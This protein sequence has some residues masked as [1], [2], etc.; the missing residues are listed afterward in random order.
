MMGTYIPVAEFRSVSCRY[1]DEPI[2]KGRQSVCGSLSCECKRKAEKQR[3]WN[4]TAKRLGTRKMKPKLVRYIYCHVCLKLFSRARHAT[5]CGEECRKIKNKSFTRFNWKSVRCTNPYVQ[6]KCQECGM[7]F[8]INFLASSRVFC[9]K[10]CL[11]REHKRNINHKR[12]TLLRAVGSV[13]MPKVR[14][15]QICE[16]DRWKCQLCYKPVS[17]R[18]KYP[19]PLSAS[20]DHIIPVAHGGTHQPINVQLAHFECNWKRGAIGFAQLRLLA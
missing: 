14:R 8:K 20:L 18:L 11:N 12:R 10:K 9:S 16:R 5:C 13:K 19:H 6:K 15:I 17:P 7:L 1:C 4:Q 2:A 3:R